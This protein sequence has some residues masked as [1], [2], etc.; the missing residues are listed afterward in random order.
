MSKYLLALAMIFSLTAATAQTTL[1]GRVVDGDKG[2]GVGYATVALLRDTTVVSA[3]AAR[4]DGAFSLTTKEQGEMVLE[5]SSVGYGTVK[6]SVRV[7]GKR[8][9]S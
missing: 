4:S 2:V 1:L 8:V 6:Q 9:D 5:V 3:V 7:S